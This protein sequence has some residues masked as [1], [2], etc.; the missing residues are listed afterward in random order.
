MEANVLIISL[1]RPEIM[2][3]LDS[4]L[5]EG[6]IAAL[7]RAGDDPEIGAVV[8]TA[9]GRGFCAGGYMKP[10]EIEITPALVRDGIVGYARDI[11]LPMYQLEKPIIGAINGAA[12][13][14]GCNLALAC[15][16]IF[17]S[18]KASF[19]QSFVNVGLIPD[20][21]G[22]YFPVSYTHL[23]VYKRQV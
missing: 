20:F 13:G 16:I 21:A 2:N 17:A 23:D 22:L 18:E 10:V 9:E 14:G 19:I 6:F 8:L 11:I 7:K 3:A 12:A 1:N 15:D 5:V 4:D